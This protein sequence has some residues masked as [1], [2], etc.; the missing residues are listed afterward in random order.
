MI[1]DARTLADGPI[2][3]DVCIVGGGAAGISLA[4]ELADT[5]MRVCMLESGGLE[6][7]AAAQALLRG[8]L[9]GSPYP[10][11][12]E[13]R[14]AALGG[15]TAVWAGWCR[16]LDPIDFEAREWIPGSGWPF[17]AGELLPFYAR[18]HALCGLGPFDYDP[19][20]W[21]ARTGVEPLRLESVEFE[22][23]MFHI[24]P[25]AFGAHYRPIL[26]RMRNVTAVLHATALHLDT[27]RD[28]KYV[29]SVR[30]ASAARRDFAVRAR[31]F[32]LAAGGIENPRLL[33]LSGQS[34]ERGVGNANG[35]V[36][37]Y[38]MEHGFINAGM[39]VGGAPESLAFHFPMKIRLESRDLTVRGAFA[40]SPGLS[41]RERLLG[42]AIFLH[43]AYEAHAVFD[44]PEVKAMLEIWDKLRGRAVPGGYARRA[45]RA[46]RA[47]WRAA[48]ALGRRAF[49]RRA[50]GRWRTRAIFECAPQRDNRVVLSPER[51]ALGRPRARVP[52]RPADRDLASVERVHALLDAALRRTGLGRF[53]CRLADDAEWRAAVEGG[54]HHMGTTRMHRDPAHG[55]VD[56]DCRVHGV[57]NLYVAG[58]SVFPTG[59][60][61]NPTLTIVALAVRLAA[62]L[63]GRLTGA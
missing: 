63:R 22:P 43:P 54:K 47:P 11:L 26:A 14:L 59:G 18:A 46:L 16:P 20:S 56:A 2:E 23:R 61:A 7:E 29:E 62:H 57:D 41:S 17:A 60:F 15:S 34:P 37:R 4:V 30:V 1:V 5:P 40:P 31:I 38:F 36:G 52:W 6:P 8:T 44:T 9:V 33:L 58:S 19:S 32:V 24:S 35:L 39:Y 51:D 27:D 49:V 53:E 28:G 48:H 50:R 42:G 13:T 10:E 3:C 25:L 12:H 55:V 21:A 45:A